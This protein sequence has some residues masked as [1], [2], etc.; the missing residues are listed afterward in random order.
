MND[1]FLC[2]ASNYDLPRRRT[3]ARKFV[4]SEPERRG[5]QTGNH[6]SICSSLHMSGTLLHPPT[7]SEMI[8][9]SVITSVCSCIAGVSDRAHLLRTELHAWGLANTGPV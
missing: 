1:S 4:S 9:P 2:S 7:C 8:V 5:R 3:V 6:P